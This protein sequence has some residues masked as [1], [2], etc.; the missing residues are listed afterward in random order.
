MAANCHSA[1]TTL[2]CSIVATA[3]RLPVTRFKPMICVSD[4]NEPVQASL[5]SDRGSP[6]ADA[7][8]ASL[9][10]THAG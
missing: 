3:F 9:P 7:E 4:D 2:I 6:R 5:K 10:P 1:A 8:S